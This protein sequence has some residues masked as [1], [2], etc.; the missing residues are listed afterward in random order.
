MDADVCTVYDDG[1]FLFCSG[2]H[3]CMI[4]AN[5]CKMYD[6]GLFLF[7]AAFWGDNLSWRNVCAQTHVV[8]QCRRNHV[9]SS[10]RTC[11][12]VCAITYVITRFGHNN[13]VY[14]A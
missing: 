9:V 6:D 1:L 14:S 4:D 8:T 10:T 2:G 12:C 5:D 13:V 3:A 11:T 7:A